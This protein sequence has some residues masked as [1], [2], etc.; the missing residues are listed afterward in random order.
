MVKY[1]SVC[2]GCEKSMQYFLSKLRTRAINIDCIANVEEC[3]S[4]TLEG[5]FLYLNSAKQWNGKAMMKLGIDYRNSNGLYF[6]EL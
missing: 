2:K 4:Y 5:A 3:E 6:G 1:K